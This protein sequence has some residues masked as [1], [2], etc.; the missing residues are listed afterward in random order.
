MNEEE[1]N[2]QEEVQDSKIKQAASKAGKQIVD[3][4]KRQISN[5]MKEVAAKIWAKVVAVIVAHLP[6]ILIILAIIASCILLFSFFDDLIDG[7]VA[8][9]IDEVTYQSINE[10][11]TIDESGVHFD[12]EKFVTTLFDK[13]KNE[14]GINLSDLGLGEIIKDQNGNEY[15]NPDSQVAEYLYKYMGASLSSELPYIEGS[16]EE[17]KGTIK[18]KRTLNSAKYSNS[19]GQTP[20]NPTVTSKTIDTSKFGLTPENVNITM[21]NIKNEYKIAWVSDLHMMHP[22]QPTINNDWYTSHGTTFEQR[23][24]MF[25]NSYLKLEN[26]IDCLKNNDFDAIVF[27]G[28]IMDNYSDKNFEYLKRKIDTISDKKI[29]FLVADHDYLTEMTTNSGDNTS[30]SSLGVG[31][32]IKKVTIGKD[33]DSINLVGQNYSNKQISDS[34]VSTINSYL[35]ETSNSLFFTHV[36]VESKT[37]ASA[38]QEWSRNVHNGQVYYWSKEASSGYNNPSENYLNTLY[39]SSSLKGLFAGH[40]HSS[41]DFELNTGKKEHIFKASFNDSIGVITITP[42]NTVQDTPVDIIE[43]SNNIEE[44]E[45]KYIGYQKLQEMINSDDRNIKEQSLRYFSL[46][47]SWNLCVTKWKKI[48][49]N[50]EEK[51]YE[52]YEVKI[53]YRRMISQYTVPFLFL[54]DLQMTSL[55]ANYVEAVADLV[56]NQSFI[57]FTIFDSVT[58]DETTYTYKA[59]RHTRKKHEETAGNTITTSYTETTEEEGPDVTVTKVEIDS[60]KANVTR[61][62]TWIIDQTITYNLQ[63]NREYPYGEKP[64]KVEKTSESKPSGEGTW[65][66]PIEKTWYEE[67]IKREWVKGAT[68][69]KFMPSEFLGLWSNKTGKY[70]KGAKYLPTTES[71]GGKLV[72]YNMLDGIRMEKPVTNIIPS[73]EILYDL[74]ESNQTTQTHSEIMKE[75]I[76]FYL[77]GEELKDG[78]ESDIINLYN[79]SEFIDSMFGNMND[80]TYASN[81]KEFIHSFEGTPKEANGKYVVFDD[82]FGNPTV[83]WGIY[84][85]SHYAR[86]AARGIDATKLKVGDLVDKSIVDSIEDEIIAGYRAR[87]AEIVNRIRISRISNRCT[88]K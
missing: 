46:D 35:N 27:G 82:G 52:I 43:D 11:C 78:L 49:E 40:V 79:P 71:S 67:I 41:G 86:F 57:D 30:A 1:N 18:I 69:T 29:M 39:N 83:G 24:S 21:D 59:T 72:E 70:E 48:S 60:I 26:I 88:Y 38:M 19:V 15:L 36:P 3:E 14:V 66:D 10:Y 25:N 7:E 77:T 53:P 23:N 45:L 73:R 2:E 32:D 6:A 58:T 28:D 42:S 81:L 85:K 8:E 4:A 31:G 34:N 47:P 62:K 44:I 65:R 80:Y 56:K 50:G 22:D 54:I 9:T 74:L 87:V 12:K 37:Q 64:G 20:T 33:G 61:A 17:T 76:N 16:D 84:I 51:S 5:K 13:L 55:N 63:E 75:I 68:E